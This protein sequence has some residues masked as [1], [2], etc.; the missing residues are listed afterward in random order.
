MSTWNHTFPKRRL[1]LMFANQT[2]LSIALAT[3]LIRR[4]LP[5]ECVSRRRKYLF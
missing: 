3:A 1:G 2:F 4:P 5:S